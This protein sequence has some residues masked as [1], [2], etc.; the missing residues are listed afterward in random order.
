MKIGTVIADFKRAY[1]AKKK[2]VE[3]AKEDFEFALGKQWQDADKEKLR[4][5]G[6]AALT[7]NKIQ[8]NIFL[9]SGIQRQN[10]TDFKAFPEGEEDGL[11]ADITTH[12]LKNIM[13]QTLGEHK[14]SEIFEDGIICGEGWVEPYLD[15]TYDMINGEMKLKKVSPFNVYVDPDSTEYDLSDAEFV[16]KLTPSLSANQA[17]KLFP[18]KAS[19]IKKMADGRLSLDPELET[20]DFGAEIQRKGYEDNTADDWAEKK[21][22][23]FD[24]TEYHYKKY[25]KKYILANKAE[26]KLEE[27][28]NKEEAEAAAEMINSETP[29]SAIVIDRVVPEIWTCALLGN[30]IMDDYKCT[31]YPRW[32]SFP[33]IPF[34][35]HRITT[36][37]KNASEYLVQGVVRSLKDPQRELN[38]RRT[39]E[40]RLL[41]TS[42]N[43]G[44][45]SRIN[46]WVN[47]SKVKEFGS[48]AGVILEWK[49]DIKPEKIQPTQ[50]SQ[51]HAQLAAENAQDMKE[52]SGIN[53]DLLAMNDKSQ[54]G[55]AIHLRQQ[56]GIVMIQRMLDN[57]SQTKRVLAKFI[58]TQL[59]ELY[60][61]DTAIRVVG[62]SFIQEHFSQPVM[63]QSPVDGSEVPVME[64][65]EMKMELDEEAVAAVFN[66]ILNDAEI[67]KY[68]VSV[69]EGANTETVRY[70]NYLLLMEL[71]QNGVLIPSDILI[72]ESLINT[73]SKEKIKKAVQLAA[74]KQA[75]TAQTGGA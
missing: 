32:K 67:G 8:P 50:L 29:N 2:W 11:T 22:K 43:S 58:L 68:D 31:F 46:S 21:E 17:V 60:T 9:L 14:L 47:K 7:I 70:S 41:N 3:E 61:V 49:G 73:G 72:E 40:L 65:G 63:T 44:W 6:V 74:Q 57:F 42:A 34:F 1:S 10:R 4:K 38:K 33:L 15:Y 30:E 45:L 18:D 75:Q 59:G 35:A 71:A 19:K 20:G 23:S 56:Q 62:N 36:Y 39:Q 54:S 25:V 28:D 55:R 66:Q 48:S 53:T 13:K 64:N 24:L 69:G 12:L 37:I 52:I 27:F 51:G 5:A 16:I 26:G